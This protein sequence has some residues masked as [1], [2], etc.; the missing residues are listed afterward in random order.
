MNTFRL[1]AGV[2]CAAVVV[3]AGTGPV[4]AVEDAPLVIETI[5]SEDLTTLGNR[6]ISEL[7]YLAPSLSVFGGGSY[8]PE[9]GAGIKFRGI[10]DPRL[11]LSIEGSAA[12]FQP[13][14]VEELWVGSR[15]GFTL[16]DISKIEIV[17]S[18]SVGLIGGTP[19]YRFGV[20]GELPVLPGTDLYLEATSAGHFG[21]SPTDIGI[22]G[23]LHFY[24]GRFDD[25]DDDDFEPPRRVSLR[26]IVE[27]YLGGSVTAVPDASLAIPS[28]DA[29]LRYNLGNGFDVGIRASVGTQIPGGTYEIWTGGELGVEISSLLR[30]YGF[31]EFGSIGGFTA[32]RIGVGLEYRVD[33]SISL[34]GELS[35]RGAPG[36]F[37]EFGVKIGGRY[38]LSPMLSDGGSFAP[39]DPGLGTSGFQP[40]IGKSISALSTG[41]FIPALDFGLTFPMD[42]GFVPGLRGQIGYQLPAAIIEGWGGV[43]LGF[44]AT[45]QLT[46]YVFGDVGSIGGFA[47]NKIGF[48][49]Q[50]EIFDQW[51]VTVEDFGRGGLGTIS[52]GG[53]T[54]GLRY[55]FGA[56]VPP[57]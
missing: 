12:L 54:A 26:N 44:A 25:Y 50:Y 45:P 33:P 18:G 6:D 55:A 21:F 7:L 52:E 48:G 37:S 14:S 2:S 24:P 41:G 46:P 56:P 31:G 17:G 13:G 42:S 38:N 16:D 32:N 28:I 53:L 30:G 35:G 49:A 5:G 34:V 23:G 40:Y 10:S 20:G 1:L 47:A 4:W 57:P 9:I 27:G 22:R 11:N 51:A 29:G 3:C 36:D 8:A 39:V 43:Q 19:S 15:L